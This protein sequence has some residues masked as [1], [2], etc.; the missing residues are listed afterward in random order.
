[1]SETSNTPPPAPPSGGIA[2]PA[3]LGLAGFAMTTFILSFANANLISEK[4]TGAFVLGLALFYGG[5]AQFLAGMWE[6]RRGNTFGATA[7]SSFG[8]FWLTEWAIARFGGGG[9]AY[10]TEGL[11]LFAWFIFTAYMTVAALRTNGAVLAVFVLLTV[12]FLLLAIGTWQH[13]SN[14]P[15]LFTRLGGW[16]GIATALAAWYASFASVVNETHKK[17]WFPTWPR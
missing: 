9:D 8:A 3:P 12:T 1:M 13:S 17:Q 16:V 10:K 7:F 5:I 11:F 14:P 4:G 15:A 2:D 6:Y